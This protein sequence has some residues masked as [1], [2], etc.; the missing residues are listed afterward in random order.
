MSR[1]Q[2]HFNQGDRVLVLDEDLMGIVSSISG[3]SIV[4]ITDDD[5]EIEFDS[6]ELVLMNSTISK[7]DFIPDNVSEVLSEKAVEKYKKTKRVKPK[8]RNLPPMVVDL[9]IHQLIPKSKGM[10][11]YDM[12]TIQTDTAKRQLEFA[13][14]KRIQRIVFIHGIG[15]GVLKAELE[16][17]FRQYGNLQFNDADYQK[18]GRG[19][20]EVYIFQNK[21]P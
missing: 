4:V 6:S 13:I 21:E 7:R 17:L 12:L 15:E 20:T 8:E 2:Q 5:F 10:N 18:Y 9:H 16:Y 19:A 3:N 1:Q 14:K 11:N